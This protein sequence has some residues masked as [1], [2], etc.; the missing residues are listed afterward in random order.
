MHYMSY[1]VYHDGKFT[2]NRVVR[3][4]SRKHACR[5]IAIWNN[6]PGFTQFD[7]HTP[8]S[9]LCGPDCDTGWQ[10]RNARSVDKSE[11]MTGDNKANHLDYSQY[12]LHL[13]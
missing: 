9:E 6:V 1:D 11:W 8:D 4:L 3:F 7:Q 13:A 5:V 12:D 2:C 10:Y